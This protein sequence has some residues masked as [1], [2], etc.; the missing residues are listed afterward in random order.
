MNT[1]P[2]A[3]SRPSA[4]SAVSRAWKHPLARPVAA[5]ALLLA[6]AAVFVPGFLHLEIKDGHQN[7]AVTVSATTNSG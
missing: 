1:N 7:L 3:M 5:L 4:P 6:V 2:L